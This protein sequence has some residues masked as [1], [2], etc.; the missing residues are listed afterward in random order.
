M[1]VSNANERW[2]NV[3][4]DKPS[5]VADEVWSLIK[6]LRN[7]QTWKQKSDD[8]ALQLYADMKYVGYGS[9]ASSIVNSQLLD[10]RM[11][12]NMIRS[13][14]RTLHSKIIKHRPRPVVWTDGGTW[15]QKRKAPLLEKWINGKF[16]QLKADSYFSEA[17]LWALVIGTGFV[18][19]SSDADGV[20]LEVIPPFEVLVDDSEARY[21]WKSLRNVYLVRAVDRNVL[22]DQ[23]PEHKKAIEGAR[24]MQGSREWLHGLGAW[25]RENYDS[26]LVV[27][28]ECFHLPSGKDSGDGRHIITIDGDVLLDEEWKRDHFPLAVMQGERRL[29][30]AFGIG[31]AEDLMGA[32]LELNQA[33]LATKTHVNLLSRAFWAI[34]RGSKIVRSSIN[35]MIGRVVEYTKTPPQLISPN[36]VPN[37]L[38]TYRNTLKQSMLDARGVSQLSVQGQKPAWLTSG[39]ALSV[40]TDME[41]ELLIDP[42]RAYEE[43]VLETAQLMVEE[44]MEL[45]AREESGELDTKEHVAT[46]LGRGEYETI[47]WR[48][49]QLP[50]DKFRIEILP[51]SAL[52]ASA[53][54]RLQSVE[55][56]KNL[57]VVTDPE[58][59]RD[60]LDMPDL[61]RH[62]RR[63]NANRDLIERIIEQKILTEGKAVTPHPDWD[64]ELAM[65][66]ALEAIQEAEMYEDAPEDRISLLRDF[67][68]NIQALMERAAP[69]P[70]G[71]PGAVPGAAA[72]DPMAAGVPGAV[73]GVPGMDSMA[74][75]GPAMSEE[76]LAAL[77][78]PG[79]VLPPQ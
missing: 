25:D 5:Q 75:P 21:G 46:V 30:G 59:M 41:S 33:S 14:T 63:K 13:V 74:G 76:E 45:A 49:A 23:F 61:R 65:E 55:D 20:H 62:K 39:K 66:M 29:M 28:A 78:P 7:K 8:L 17:C 6:R 53:S 43:L 24:A 12:D 9:S 54:A 52:S 68:L 31:V 16:R 27:T 56:L 40:W 42:I 3:P 48:D 79:Q 26:D 72:M 38:W 19:V 22:M 11:G 34:E 69:A 35:N 47:R 32:Q 73:P 51:T 67:V 70:A 4:E 44:Q 64:L 77:P 37:E 36:A 50:D 71:A 1:R 15:E 18:R 60:L 10:A 58:E 2:Y 57:G